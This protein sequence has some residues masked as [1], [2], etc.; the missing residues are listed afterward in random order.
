MATRR[1]GVDA[2]DGVI[3]AVGEE[4]GEG[5]LVSVCPGRIGGNAH[6]AQRENQRQ[7][8]FAESSHI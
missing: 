6:N 8:A 3:E 7:Q 5:I 4:M 2:L 1:D